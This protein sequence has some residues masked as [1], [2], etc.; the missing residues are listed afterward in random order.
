M[1]NKKDSADNNQ[2]ERRYKT[3]FDKLDVNDD[4]KINFN[5]LLRLIER[6]TKTKS[7]RDEDLSRAKV[8]C[9][10]YRFFCVRREKN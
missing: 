3:L 2:V 9:V 8:K 4:G 6:K 10:N 5:D 7:E 1:L